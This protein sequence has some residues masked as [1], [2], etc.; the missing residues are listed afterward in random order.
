MYGAGLGIY[1]RASGTDLSIIAECAAKGTIPHSRDVYLQLNIQL[2]F[3]GLTFG[4]A[5][6]SG[7]PCS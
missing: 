6:R 7:K 4:L 1:A 5:S 2:N 3:R